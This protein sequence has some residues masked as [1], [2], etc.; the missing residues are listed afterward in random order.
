MERKEAIEIIK[1]NWPDSSFTMLR[2]ALET[3]VPELKESED[4]RIRKWIIDD[5]RY[6]MN[7]EQLNN[8]EYK[9]KAEKAIAWLEKQ[10]EQKISWSEE[11]ER[12]LNDIILFIKT[13]TYS[14][15]K[16][17]LI[18]WLKSLRPQNRWNDISVPPKFPCDILF[19]YPNGN[20][21]IFRYLENGRKNSAETPIFSSLEEGEWIYL[22]DIEPQPQWKP[23]DEQIRRLEY[24]L[25]L[26]GKTDDIENIKV[27]ETVKSLLNDLKKL[28][29]K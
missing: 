6:N 11:D 25:K 14:L 4:E 21:F 12:N 7:N 16:E 9:K 26:W 28:R 3:L 13:G 2:E 18:D 8:S 1:K 24:F 27:F 5:I 22:D 29:E 19:K 23:S 17:K 10:G 20:K 15:D